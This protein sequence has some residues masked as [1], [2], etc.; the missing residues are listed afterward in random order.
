MS[1]LTEQL[2]GR[3]CPLFSV[4]FSLR[5]CILVMYTDVLLMILE[6]KYL[7]SSNSETF[8]KRSKEAT[9]Y[10]LAEIIFTSLSAAFKNVFIF[11]FPF[12]LLFVISSVAD[13]DSWSLSNEKEIV[14]SFN[15]KGLDVRLY[16]LLCKFNL[17]FITTCVIIYFT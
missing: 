17:R 6:Q 7:L 14:A 9:E 5:C 3:E 2:V 16:T 15:S 4:I 8:L 1:K 10:Y 11:C 13:Q 12:F